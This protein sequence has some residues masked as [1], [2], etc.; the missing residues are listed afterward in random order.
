MALTSLWGLDPASYAPHALHGAE[1]AW[2]ETSCYV[3]VWIELCAARGVDPH[4]ILGFAIATDLEADQWTFLRPPHGDLDELLGARVHELNL[5]RP[6][7]EHAVEQ[8]ARGRI[9]V[10][11]MDSFW[12]PDTRGV[13]YQLTHGK[14]AIAIEAIDVDGERLRY[15]HNAGYFELGGAD[16]RGALRTEGTAPEV[17]SP[18]CELVD[19]SAPR[20]PTRDNAWRV[21]R[22]HAARRPTTNPVDALAARF[23]ARD[24]AWLREA[25]L[26]GL[27]AWSFGT[28]RMAG[29][30]AEL[31]ASHLRWLDGARLEVAAAAFDEA[32]MGC[33]ALQF[34]LARS[35][36]SGRAVDAAG[37]FAS[38][39]AAWQ[40]GQDEVTRA[41][42]AG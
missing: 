28:L 11:D 24:G 20:T 33:K 13:S 19:W 7:A 14:T 35:L 41:L 3:D 42:E 6:L 22:R 31:V 2:P 1:R 9:L 36:V 30:A 17:L 34:K 37:A 40:R 23:A 38:I 12:L 8:I 10:V 29:A 21:L 18:Y 26:P 39:A 27:H 32:S 4:A 25:G 16:F 5:W 15:F